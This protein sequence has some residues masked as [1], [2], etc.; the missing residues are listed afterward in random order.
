MV[1]SNYDNDTDKANTL[2]GHVSDGYAGTLNGSNGYLPPVKGS[3]FVQLEG[4]EP[5]YPLGNANDTFTKNKPIEAKV[6]ATQQAYEAWKEADVDSRNEANKSSSASLF[7]H[8]TR[9]RDTQAQGD[10]WHEPY[11]RRELWAGRPDATF[12]QLQKP[13]KDPLGA[14]N[15]SHTKG[16]AEAE[17][18][19]STQGVEE[20]DATGQQKSDEDKYDAKASAERKVGN[21]IVEY[22]AAGGYVHDS[23]PRAPYT[24]AYLQEDPAPAAA[25][26]AKPAEEAKAAAPAKEGEEK[27]ADPKEQPKSPSP[28]DKLGWANQ[29][30]KE[31]YSESAEV[32]RK[33]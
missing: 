21:G 20:A 33:Q 14:A 12:L 24:H 29:T 9:A 32:V 18:V 7:G 2:K 4:V 1:K 10:F 15:A 5:A 30:K 6:V 25:K 27:K 31:G 8:V 23:Y 13:A 16:V 19:V 11:P 3:S 26:E 22:Q 28:T 17:E